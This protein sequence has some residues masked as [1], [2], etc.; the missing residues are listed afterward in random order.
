MTFSWKKNSAG[1]HPASEWSC[2]LFIRLKRVR[3][4]ESGER[5]MTE[6]ENCEDCG[7]LCVGRG[8]MKLLETYFPGEERKT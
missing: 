3:G 6:N 2:I 1:L 7:C 4:G 8:D 5:G